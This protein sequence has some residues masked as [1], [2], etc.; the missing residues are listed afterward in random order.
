[1]NTEKFFKKVLVICKLFVKLVI[2]FS[3]NVVLLIKG[4]HQT[5]IYFISVSNFFSHILF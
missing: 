5:T 4:V 3:E 1:M 2:V